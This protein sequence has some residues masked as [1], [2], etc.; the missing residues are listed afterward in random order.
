MIRNENSTFAYLRINT[1]CHILITYRLFVNNILARLT[2]WYW[3]IIMF[4]LVMQARYQQFLW[5]EPA[6]GLSQC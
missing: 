5:T 6:L 4:M 1:T 2:Y 3:Y